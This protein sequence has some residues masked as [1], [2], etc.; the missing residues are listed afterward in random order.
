M[1]KAGILLSF[2]AVLAITLV[3]GHKLV[4][5]TSPRHC[6]DACE[7]MSAIACQ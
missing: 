7:I 3:S 5:C 2:M 1:P 6:L 4:L